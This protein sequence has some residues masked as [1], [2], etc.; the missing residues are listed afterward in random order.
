[1]S[2]VTTILPFNAFV[3]IRPDCTVPPITNYQHSTLLKRSQRI[4]LPRI[5]PVPRPRR[6]KYQVKAASYYHHK[7]VRSYN[8]NTCTRLPSPRHYHAR[9]QKKRGG[10]LGGGCKTSLSKWDISRGTDLTDQSLFRYCIADPDLMLC[11]QI[12]PRSLPVERFSR[13]SWTC[14][15]LGHQYGVGNLNRR[16]GF[17]VGL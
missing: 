14:R 3:P 12:T 9:T 16:A 13:I 2:S 15:C 5:T 11:P 8:K 7:H 17:G 6:P 4:R 10:G 1:M